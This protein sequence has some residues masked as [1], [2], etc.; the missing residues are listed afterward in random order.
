MRYSD[1]PDK[2]IRRLAKKK[3]IDGIWGKDREE[4]INLIIA[5]GYQDDLEYLNEQLMF[6]GRISGLTLERAIEKFPDDV[7]DKDKF[8]KKLIDNKYIPND[9]I[10][11]KR[12]YPVLEDKPQI[13]GIS[14][15]GDTVFI[16]TVI[17]KTGSY[18]NG[19]HERRPT[20]YAY[21]VVIVIHFTNQLIEYRC[22][23]TSVRFY[24][25]FI[26]SILG[27]SKVPP[28]DTL[29]KL[30]PEEARLVKEHL[31]A[32]YSTE[33]ISIPSTVGTI[34]FTRANGNVDLD[35]DRVALSFKEAISS[36]NYP[37]NDQINVMCNLDDFADTVT[38]V[39][40]P[41]SF[42][43]NLKNGSLKFTNSS[44][45]TQAAIDH[46]IDAIFKIAYVDKQEKSAI[47]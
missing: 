21:T 24:K 1:V 12:W 30:T 6:S 44:I 28:F 33:L 42:E 47:I 35:T 36:L 13:S 38:G 26:C 22:A 8:I 10:T 16:Q 4:I 17:R 37:T 14:V 39:E 19:Y 46:I 3:N 23:A 15:D 18:M 31:N 25:N 41:I 32:S 9:A 20:E 2:I 29:T 34:T 43:I 40:N 45:V 11:R 5:A 27:Y 7:S